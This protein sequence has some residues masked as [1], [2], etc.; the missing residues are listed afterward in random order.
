MQPHPQEGFAVGCD[1]H[2]RV[3]A[4]DVRR[5]F[6]EGDLRRVVAL[7]GL[8]D[9]VEALFRRG[10]FACRSVE[11]VFLQVLADLAVLFVHV[12]EHFAHIRFRVLLLVVHH[13]ALHVEVQRREACQNGEQVD[14]IDLPKFALHQ[15]PP[16]CADFTRKAVGSLQEEF[17]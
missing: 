14:E 17:A 15:L 9:A 2:D 12:A 1:V 16:S 10:K 5:I 8:D 6:L 7:Q 4:A 11:R 13:D 3:H